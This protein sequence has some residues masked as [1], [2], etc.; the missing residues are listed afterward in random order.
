MPDDEEN[1]TIGELVEADA[2]V[3]VGVKWPLRNLQE[4]LCAKRR[5]I[6]VIVVKAVS[7]VVELV[8]DAVVSSPGAVDG[9]DP[10]VVELRV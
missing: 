2:E 10:R 7:L 4:S 5:K 3:R 9:A 6:P 8:D 1:C